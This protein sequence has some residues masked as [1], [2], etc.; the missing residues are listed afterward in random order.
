MAKI[1]SD[2]LTECY[3]LIYEYQDFVDHINKSEKEIDRL[4]VAEL[5]ERN[6]SGYELDLINFINEK[7]WNQE[8]GKFT[9]RKSD[10]SLYYSPHV[11]ER[12]IRSRYSDEMYNSAQKYNKNTSAGI[13]GGEDDED[14]EYNKI[15]KDKTGKVIKKIVKKREE[16]DRKGVK[17]AEK[18]R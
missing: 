17:E 2:I 9:R 14:T 1:I 13:V 18:T 11:F 3:R 6:T 16:D 5:L 10:R 15:I 4:S 12:F 8:N 7:Q